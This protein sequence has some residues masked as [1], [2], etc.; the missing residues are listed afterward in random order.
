MRLPIVALFDL[1]GFHSV[2]HG[3]GIF[4][5]IDGYVRFRIGNYRAANSDLHP[6]ASTRVVKI[7]Y[8]IRDPYVNILTLV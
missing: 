1:T 8:D 4:C 3:V 6:E 5:K 7:S 2:Y